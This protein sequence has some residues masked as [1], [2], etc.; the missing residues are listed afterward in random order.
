[1]SWFHVNGLLHLVCNI[2]YTAKSDDKARD[3]GSGK[4]LYIEYANPQVGRTS[5]PEKEKEKY[6]CIRSTARR[7]CISS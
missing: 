3:V 5:V 1:M 4:H 7:F 2:V 6:K